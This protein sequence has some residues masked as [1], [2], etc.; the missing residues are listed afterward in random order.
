MDKVNIR[1]MLK[2]DIHYVV[3]ETEREE[4]WTGRQ[5]LEVIFE[6]GEEGCFIAEVDSKRAG[7]V[8]TSCFKKSAWLGNLIVDPNFRK[9]GIGTALMSAGLEHIQSLGIKSAWLDADPPGINIYQSL[10]FKIKFESL[11]YEILPAFSD[12]ST[13]ALKMENSLLP[14]IIEFD[15]PRY[16]DDRGRLLDLLYKQAV[17][18]YIYYENGNLTGY[19]MLVPTPTGYSAGPFIADNLDAADELLKAAMISAEGKHLTLG[20]SDLNPDGV[21]LLVDYGFTTSPQSSR[22]LFGEDQRT[23][24]ESTIYGM[25]GGATG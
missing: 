15:T 3:N 19:L 20:I 8:T 17:K 7:F 13:K 14:D 10:G 21:K 5:R 9:M 16:G 12:L 4:W 1:K 18:S 23:A 11:R 6:H 24:R 22:M 25:A 2:S